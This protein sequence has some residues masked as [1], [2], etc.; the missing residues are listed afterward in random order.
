MTSICCFCL[1]SVTHQMKDDAP[2]A[3]PLPVLLPPGSFMETP[4]I[5]VAS[6]HPRGWS[7][8]GSQPNPHRKSDW[9]HKQLPAWS[10]LSCLAAENVPKPE[11]KAMDGQAGALTCVSTTGIK[12]PW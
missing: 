1:C 9:K 3:K 5:S 4:G 10:A 2:H 7:A 11:R 8:V 6:R 12:M